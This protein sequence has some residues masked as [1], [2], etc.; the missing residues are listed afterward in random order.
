MRLPIVSRSC[1]PRSNDTRRGS[2]AGH[3]AGSCVSVPY[4]PDE[5]TRSTSPAAANP[6]PEPVTAIRIVKPTPAPKPSIIVPSTSTYRFE[7]E[8][9]VD[10][11]TLF[12]GLGKVKDDSL[13]LEATVATNSTPVAVEV[14]RVGPRAF[15]RGPIPGTAATKPIWYRTSVARLPLSVPTGF[16]TFLELLRHPE[17]ASLL[18]SRGKAGQC[19]VYALD[20]AHEPAVLTGMNASAATD[21]LRF[22]ELDMRFTLCAGGRLERLDMDFV[23]ADP[24]QATTSPAL[25]MSLAFFDIGD[26]ITITPP[27]FSMPLLT[28]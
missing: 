13:H 22:E 8:L 21:A 2:V 5:H 16:S 6:L 3:G 25:T 4:D 24:G 12:E 20:E 11:A 14:I 10:D 18:V 17:L 26:A 1:F 15:V 7:M 19:T 27:A 23:A 9:A 28:S